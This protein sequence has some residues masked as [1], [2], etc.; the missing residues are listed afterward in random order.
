MVRTDKHTHHMWNN[1]AD[2]PDITADANG[3]SSSHGRYEKQPHAESSNR[4]TNGFEMCIRDSYKPVAFGI[5]CRM[6]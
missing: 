5:Y 2:K 3:G 6:Q 1:K 4:H